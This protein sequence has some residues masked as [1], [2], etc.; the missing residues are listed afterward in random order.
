MIH[1]VGIGELVVPL[2][3][4]IWDALS[5]PLALAHSLLLCLS[6]SL[7]LSLYLSLALSGLISH[8][9][10]PGSFTG[11]LLAFGESP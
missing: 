8:I 10:V 3:E 9:S 1:V 5:P 2:A 11:S 7:S 6:R 4:W